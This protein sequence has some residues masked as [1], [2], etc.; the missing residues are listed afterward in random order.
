M[1]P[2]KNRPALFE[3]LLHHRGPFPSFH[4]FADEER[5]IKPLNVLLQTC[6]H[7]IEVHQTSDGQTTCFPNS[8]SLEFSPW[9]KVRRILWCEFRVRVLGWFQ[10]VLR[11]C[12]VVGSGAGSAMVQGVPLC[13]FWYGLQDWFPMV[14]GLLVQVP[15]WFRCAPGGLGVW[16]GSP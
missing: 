7:M 13:W 15:G 9:I 11:S 6:I 8:V 2:L 1:T 3:S 14:L 12:V 10:E 16:D 5:G 4:R